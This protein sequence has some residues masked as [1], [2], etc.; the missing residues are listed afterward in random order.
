MSREFVRTG[1]AFASASSYRES[2][3][4]HRSQRRSTPLSLPRLGVK[5]LQPANDRFCQFAAEG[6]RLPAKAHQRSEVGDKRI[7]VVFEVKFEPLARKYRCTSHRLAVLS[8]K[9]HCCVLKYKDPA[10]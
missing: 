9:Q 8:G 2:F 10:D 3:A 4:P 7:A 5:I 6:G 1:R